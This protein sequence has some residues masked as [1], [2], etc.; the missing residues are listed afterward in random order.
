VT[1]VFGLFAGPSRTKR[2]P[3]AVDVT[4]SVSLCVC[5]CVKGNAIYTISFANNRP[6]P[7]NFSR[8]GVCADA[9]FGALHRTLLV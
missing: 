1:V 4:V 2:L 8:N 3:P 7:Q 9:A 5:L 6:V